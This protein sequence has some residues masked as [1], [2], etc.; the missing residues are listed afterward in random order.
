MR[1]LA[2]IAGVLGTAA[3]ANATI[4]DVNF[5]QDLMSGANEVPANASV[6]QGGELGD[7]FLYDDVANRLDINFGY[8]VFGWTPLEGNF[9]SAAIRL[10]GITENGSVQFPLQGMHL[11]LGQRGGFFAGSVNLNE[12]QE[13]VLFAGNYYISITS[14]KFPSGEI[15]GQLSV[16]PEPGT[17][18]LMGLGIGALVWFRRK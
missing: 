9:S 4:W 10:G 14:A 17:W 16:V 5:L 6:A 15:R 7:G 18:A 8:G 3:A 11:A 2:T 1:K 12:A 13:S